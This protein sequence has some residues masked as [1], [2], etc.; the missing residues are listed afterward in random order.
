MLMYYAK[1]NTKLVSFFRYYTKK[2]FSRSIF[3]QQCHVP[4]TAKTEQSE[5]I[6]FKLYLLFCIIPWVIRERLEYISRED[7]RNSVTI[8]MLC[9]ILVLTSASPSSKIGGPIY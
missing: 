9:A 2:R 6:K 7:A 5:E 8:T 3:C 1:G 4:S